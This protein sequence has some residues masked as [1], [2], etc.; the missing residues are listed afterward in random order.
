MSKENVNAAQT[1]QKV[2]CAAVSYLDDASRLPNFRTLDQDVHDLIEVL[3]LTHFLEEEKLRE[4]LSLMI[5][6]AKFFTA[7]FKQFSD[8]EIQTAIQNL[9]CHE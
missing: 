4:Q 2:L 8:Q 1:T 9:K 7:A 6:H 3:L 5:A